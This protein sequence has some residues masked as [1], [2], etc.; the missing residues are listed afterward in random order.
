M[1]ADGIIVD[2]I[3]GIMLTLFFDFFGRER[4]R[5]DNMEHR[6]FGLVCIVVRYI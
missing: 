4:W 6:R 1:D 2:G 5:V 3:G